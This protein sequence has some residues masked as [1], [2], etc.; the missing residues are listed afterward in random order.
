[1]SVEKQLAEALRAILDDPNNVLTKASVQKARAAIS[2][3]AKPRA[4]LAP[5]TEADVIELALQ[6]QF[7]L[8]CDDM[9]SLGQIVEAVQRALA[10]K[11][12]LT[13]ADRGQ[14]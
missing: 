14:G 9:E 13:L 3:E 11:N 12:G 6:E 5:L 10:A 8:I 7:L 4:V 2:A 1:M